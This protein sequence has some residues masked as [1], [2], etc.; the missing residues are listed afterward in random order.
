MSSSGSKTILTLAT[1]TVLGLVAYAVYFDYKRRN[2]VTFRKKLR[3]FS[4][5]S[6]VGG[7]SDFVPGKD[8]KRVDKT[9]AQSREAEVASNQIST[10][11]LRAALDKVKAEEVPSSPEERE[12]YFMSQV[13]MGEQICTQG[14]PHMLHLRTP[15]SHACLSGPAFNLQ[16]ALCFYKALRVYPSP[17]E[18]IVIYQKTVPDDVFKV[19]AP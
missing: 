16:A 10:E 13:G 2:D 4:P 12:Q 1:A 8:K 11:D 18:L 5:A 6:S 9:T 17:V 7:I 15:K 19:S 3:E 14:Q